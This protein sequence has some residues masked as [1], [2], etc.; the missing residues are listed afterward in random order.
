[1]VLAN[2][3]SSVV[4]VTVAGAWRQGAEMARGAHRNAS[5]QTSVLVLDGVGTTEMARGAHRNASR[6]TSCR[7]GKMLSI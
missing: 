6:Q 2:S 5:R 7:L 4:G 3:Y 1:M